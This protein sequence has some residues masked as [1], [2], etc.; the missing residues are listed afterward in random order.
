MSLV[1]LTEGARATTLVAHLRVP[2]WRLRVTSTSRKGRNP[3]SGRLI[4]KARREPLKNMPR[5]P[6]GHQSGGREAVHAREAVLA[7]EVRAGPVA[8]LR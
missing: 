6:G 8:F 7:R 5:V 4:L 1:L 3:E 2:V